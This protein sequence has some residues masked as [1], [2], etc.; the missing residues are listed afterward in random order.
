[1]KQLLYISCHS[2][3]DC[4]S[5]EAFFIF[6]F[7]QRRHLC[8]SL[9]FFSFPPFFIA[10]PCT[11]IGQWKLIPK[12]KAQTFLQILQESKSKTADIFF[13]L[14][15]DIT[16]IQSHGV[17]SLHF[18]FLTAPVRSYA[19][20]NITTSTSLFY[21]RKTIEVFCSLHQELL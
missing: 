11:I 7:L 19:E 10:H 12:N 3:G 18:Q 20:K 14:S 21:Q 17:L 1:M 9:L 13:I 8:I 15:I 2:F 16:H 6:C 5:L 4:Y